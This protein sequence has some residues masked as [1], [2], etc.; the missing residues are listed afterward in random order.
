MANA[1]AATLGRNVSL[2]SRRIGGGRCPT[3]AKPTAANDATL[4]KPN[5]PTSQS[6]GSAWTPSSG[7]L[8]SKAR[9]ASMPAAIFSAVQALISSK[10]GARRPAISK[11]I[12]APT[13]INPPMAAA[14]HS[15]LPGIERNTGTVTTVIDASPVATKRM[16]TRSG[17]RCAVD[18]SCPTAI[19]E[20][21]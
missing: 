16:S 21:T 7:R 19:K 12:S 1:G 20:N 6:T 10:S 8:N 15:P 2:E 11:A 14:N 4:A 17:L 5:G 3:A 18:C 9:T 13:H